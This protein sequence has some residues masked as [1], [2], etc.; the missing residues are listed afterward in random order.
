MQQPLKLKQRQRNE[1]ERQFMIWLPFIGTMTLSLRAMWRVKSVYHR[2]NRGVV[3][4]GL[5]ITSPAYFLGHVLPL[6]AGNRS[7]D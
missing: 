2:Y 3:R 5:C 7:R 4:S 6:L 1:N